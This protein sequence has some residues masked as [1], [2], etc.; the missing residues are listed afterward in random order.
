[1]RRTLIRILVWI[2]FF[3]GMI[4]G[5]VTFGAVGIPLIKN[6]YNAYGFSVGGVVTIILDILVG[7]FVASAVVTVIWIIGYLIQQRFFNKTQ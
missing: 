3:G 2:F 4:A 6:A 5:F 1:M 7:L